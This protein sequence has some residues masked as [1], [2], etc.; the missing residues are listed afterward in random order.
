MIESL[1]EKQKDILRFVNSDRQYLICDGAVRSGKTIVMTIAFVI[2]AMENFNNCNFAICSKT[3]SNAERNVLMPLL[4]EQELPYTFKYHRQERMLSSSIDKNHTN[5]FYLFGGKDESSYTL[6]QGIT[7]AGVLLDE[8][9]L[10]P[11][12]FVEQAM[13][14]TLTYKNKKIWFNC[15]PEGQLHW[16]NQEWVLPADRG[17]KRITHLH[18]LM[19]DNPIMGEEEI[20]QTEEMFSGVFYD[21]YIL[22][23]WVAAE[24]LIFDMF[25]ASDHVKDDVKTE[26]EYFI[27]SDFGI[28]N[29]TTFLFWRKEKG[30]EGKWHCFHEY[31]YSG[32]E[33]RKQKTVEELVSDLMKELPQNEQKEPVLPKQIIVDPSA[34]ALIVEL[35]KH[36]FKVRKAHN[37]VLDGISDVASMLNRHKLSFSSKC[38][39]T[40]NEFGVYCWDTKAAMKGEDV[41][42]KANDHCMDAVRYFVKTMGLVQKDKPPV[43]KEKHK[44]L[45]FL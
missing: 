17:E 9:A 34:A 22:G 24:G 30:I 20:K 15:N 13:A 4:N 23:L 19:S 1:S 16:F 25:R 11:R 38:I 7:L 43:Y 6:I 45:Y 37:D 2:W 28:Q 29:A 26:G 40:I 3:V 14:R 8:V 27:S 33:E 18:F 36:N 41:P 5:R 12:S 21:R 31:Y 42:V 10:M 35:R 44:N 39:N 32:R